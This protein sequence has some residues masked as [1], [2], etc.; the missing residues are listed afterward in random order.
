MRVLLKASQNSVN[1]I[2]S[3][4][5]CNNYAR[6][7]R[8]VVNNICVSQ[9]ISDIYVERFKAGVNAGPLVTFVQVGTAVLVFLLKM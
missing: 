9:V 8:N 1:S 7:Q 3:L 6:L 4:N 5:A 2:H